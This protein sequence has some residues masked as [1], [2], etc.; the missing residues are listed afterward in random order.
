MLS[1]NRRLTAAA[2]VLALNAG[3]AIA[4]AWPNKIVKFVVPFG[5]GGA[6]DLVARAAAEGAGKQLGQSIIVENKPGA[7][8]VVG[9]DYVAK[10]K[11]DGY[12]FLVGAAG[13]VTNSLIK[14]SMPYK[15]SDL[16]P[17]GMLAVS[18]SVIVVPAESPIKDLKAF[19]T[20]SKEGKGLNF[21]TA[22]TGSTPHFVAE[23]LKINAGAK[24]EV[25]PY[26]SGSEGMTAVVGNQVSATSEASIVVMPQVKAG[27]LRA[28]ASTWTKRMSAYPEIATTKELGFA[29]VQI[30]HWAG[31]FAPRGT[32]E[33][34]LEKMNKALD[35]A[36]KS[37]EIAERLSKQGIE[38]IGGSR[39]S[40]VQFI[41]AERSRLGA[42]AKAA[43]MKDE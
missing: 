36:M 41:A 6:N 34:V 16:V 37:P 11:S 30:G 14:A 19:V 4:Q 2:L 24:L 27:K 7:G 21:A 3:G 18:P 12:T 42:V 35:A 39:A 9:A 15:D 26:K 31:V 8:A 29:D 28:L 33:A 40:F 17:V 38:P 43:G 23:M 32:P 5:P 20:A 1:R 13:V 22:G 10:S 25:I